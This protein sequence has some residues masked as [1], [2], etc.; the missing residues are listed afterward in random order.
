[1][2]IQARAFNKLKLIMPA[3]LY[4]ERATLLIAKQWGNNDPW[5]IKLMVL[6]QNWLRE[7]GEIK[8]AD[9]LKAEIGSIA[10]RINTD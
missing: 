5:R 6:Q 3:V 9:D 10:E 8:A 4:L 2:E 7:N 1:M